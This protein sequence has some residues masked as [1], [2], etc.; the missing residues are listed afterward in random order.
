MRLELEIEYP[1][2]KRVRNAL[3]EL[4]RSQPIHWD[5]REIWRGCGT[6]ESVF[7]IEA[8]EADMLAIKRRRD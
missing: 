5:E 2:Q 6:M 3:K 8:S 1:H 4:Q 7:T